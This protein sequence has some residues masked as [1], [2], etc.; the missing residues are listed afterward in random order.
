M[1]VAFSGFNALKSQRSTLLQTQCKLSFVPGTDYHS[2]STLYRYF[3]ETYV[4]FPQPNFIWSSVIPLAAKCST[5]GITLFV[6][7]RFTI[8]DEEPT[9][10]HDVSSS[11]AE[12]SALAP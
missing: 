2:N 10:L 8:R 12:C 9:P 1:C 6:Q 5:L 11:I 4:P 7:A 3:R